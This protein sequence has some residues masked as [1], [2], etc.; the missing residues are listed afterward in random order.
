MA[1]VCMDWSFSASAFYSLWRVNFDF[2]DRSSSNNKFC[3]K[4]WA[5]FLIRLIFSHSFRCYCVPF[6]F[7]VGFPEPVAIYT[8]H[9]KGGT[10][11]ISPGKNVPG[12]SSNVR[13]APGPYGR[14]YKSTEFLGNRNSYIHFPNNGKLSV[15]NSMTLLAWVYPMK[16]GPIFEYLHGVKFWCVD[17]DSLYAHFVRRDRRRTRVLRKRRLRPYRWNYVGAT[18]DQRTGI[19]TLWLNSRPILSVNIGKGITLATTKDAYMGTGFRGRISCMQ[20][21]SSALTGP[22]ISKLRNLCSKPGMFDWK[23]KHSTS[24]RPL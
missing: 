3:L 14:S 16:P 24:P 17:S 18:Y 2:K 6:F 19:A 10:V 11:D 12:Q 5:I 13:Y 22:Q 4:K 21:Y 23:F 9:R 15:K 1:V 20:I 7:I 8:L